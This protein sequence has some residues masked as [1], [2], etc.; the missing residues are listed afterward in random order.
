MKDVPSIAVSFVMDGVMDGGTIGNIPYDH[1]LTIYMNNQKVQAPI[2][3]A[4]H[5]TATNIIAFRML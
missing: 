3:T 1:I 4:M 2:I 5:N